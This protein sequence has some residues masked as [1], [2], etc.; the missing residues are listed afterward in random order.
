MSPYVVSVDFVKAEFGF[1]FSTYDSLWALHGSQ[2]K[3]SIVNNW[4]KV[5]GFSLVSEWLRT[6]P[7]IELTAAPGPQ[8]ISVLDDG[9]L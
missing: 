8:H 5:I 6:H 7:G 2:G 9:K 1:W 4:I 3:V